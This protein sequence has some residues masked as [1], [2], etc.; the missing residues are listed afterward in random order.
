MKNLTI[1]TR[2]LA[3][4]SIVS[5]LLLI[6]IATAVN[7]L[8]KSGDQLENVNRVSGLSSKVAKALVCIKNI[9]ESSIL[10]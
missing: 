9:D 2:L 6:V 3:G 5:L 4:F 7:G 8:Y 1:G 10:A